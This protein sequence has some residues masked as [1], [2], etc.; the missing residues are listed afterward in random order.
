MNMVQGWVLVLPLLLP[1][2][3]ARRI[4]AHWPHS[5]PTMAPVCHPSIQP[6]IRSSRV[7]SCALWIL[8]EYS[9]S[10]E[11]VEAAVDVIKQS[12]G[13]MPLLVKEGEWVG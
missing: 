12:L 11:D 1:C 5:L 2:L 3:D 7:C 10:V 6:Q 4:W 13:P 8:G 9:A